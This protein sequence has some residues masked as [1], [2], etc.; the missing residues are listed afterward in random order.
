MFASPPEMLFN[1]LVALP[2]IFKNIG[3]LR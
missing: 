3:V 2:A 1:A